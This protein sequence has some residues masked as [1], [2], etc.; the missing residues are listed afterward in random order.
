M[1]SYKAVLQF[2]SKL[3]RQRRWKSVRED[4]TTAVC[5]TRSASEHKATKLIVHLKSCHHHEKN[6]ATVSSASENV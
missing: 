5:D 6:K 3:R 2:V 4:D 1:Q